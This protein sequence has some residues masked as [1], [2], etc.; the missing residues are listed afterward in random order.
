MEYIS[1]L[2]KLL[3]AF[4][5]S[6]VVS[7]SRTC[8]FESVPKLLSSDTKAMFVVKCNNSNLH[9]FFSYSLNNGVWATKNFKNH[10]FE[11]NFGGDSVTGFHIGTDCGSVTRKVLTF[12]SS[13]V[14][15]VEK[16]SNIRSVKTPLLLV[17][18][19]AKKF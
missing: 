12:K 17:V 6:N 18:I 2:S 10:S 7:G 13:S 5:I 16:S 1:P 15:S 19:A 8:H 11:N 9:C 3:L 4:L 14:R